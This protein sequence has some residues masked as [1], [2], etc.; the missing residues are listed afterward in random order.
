MIPLVAPLIAACAPW[1]VP[2]AKV[3]DAVVIGKAYDEQN[4]F[5][6]IVRHETRVPVVY[7]D[8]NV[9]AFMDYEPASPGH[10]LV[11]SKTSKARNLLEVSDKDLT[12]L[13]VVA[14]RVGRAEISGLGADGFTVEQNNGLPQ[15]VPHLHVHVLPR[16]IGF[17]R[18]RGGGLRQ[19]NEVLEPFAAR[20]RV[21]LAADRGQPVPPKPTDD[22]PV[23]TAL[24][25]QATPVV[26][27]KA[28]TTDPVA[29]AANPA[30]MAAFQLPSH[31]AL[32]NA[33]MYTASGAEPHPTMLLLHG[34]PGNEQNLDLAQ[35]VRRAGWNVLTLHYR[36]SWGS[37]GSFSFGHAAEDA[38]AALAFLKSPD[39]TARFHIDP[40]RIVVAGH[41]MGGMM[42]AHA[43]ASDKS[44]LGAILIDAWDIASDGR[45][46]ANDPKARDALARDEVRGDLPPLAGTSEAALVDEIAH[47]PPSLDLAAT[48]AQIKDMPLLVIGAERAG[49][50]T[51]RAVAEA[52]R[53]AG[54]KHVA[55]VIV[56]TDHPFSDH[57]IELEAR[58]IDWLGQFPR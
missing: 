10:V 11:I 25:P 21:A 40:A 27:A 6:K 31:G 49:A 29:D 34:F 32:L 12:R 7:E 14:R 45:R 53:A 48:A 47:A 46:I 38:D 23:P 35:A 28:I 30:A 24:A 8:R 1:G 22:L 2:P 42:A 4:P 39:A 56:P 3:P 33:V 17:N 13:L 55:L 9:I 5:A 54:G 37:P 19:P 43:A 57:R 16:Y 50:P 15:S 36:G 18:C 41:S 52:A 51:A 20:L 58:V 26:P 44:V